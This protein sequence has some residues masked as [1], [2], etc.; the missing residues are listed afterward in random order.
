MGA[1]DTAPHVEAEDRDLAS[2]ARGAPRDGAGSLARD[3]AR[4]VRPSRP[5]VRGRGRGGPLLRLGRQPRRQGGLP[6]D[7]ALL[8][9]AQAAQRVGPAE[10]GARR[11]TLGGG[12]DGAGQVAAVEIAKANGSWS[13]LDAVERLAVPDDLAA[14]L[15]ARPPARLHWDAFPPLRPAGG[16][17]VDLAGAPAGDAGQAG[18]RDVGARAAQ[19]AR[20]PLAAQGVDAA[21]AVT[22]HATA[23]RS[24]RPPGGQLPELRGGEQASSGDA[25]AAALWPQ[26]V[27]T[28]TK[29][30]G[31]PASSSRPI[32]SSAGH[33]GSNDPST[34]RG[35]GRPSG[36]R[37]SPGR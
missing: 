10:Q 37:P 31:R 18:R 21:A 30:S 1:F 4:R 17:R 23:T 28:P 29:V 2:L 27:A 14:A 19:R 36:R 34:P 22:R 7:E 24:R 6:T 25:P 26:A 8:R 13:A 12:A 15:D 16:P 32:P 9:A 11:A 3:L 35:V 20:Q 5:R 33:R